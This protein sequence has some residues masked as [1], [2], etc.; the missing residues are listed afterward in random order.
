[1][2]DQVTLPGLPSF[3]KT[4]LGTSRDEGRYGLVLTLCEVWV[5]NGTS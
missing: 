2:A 5:C 1:M 3:G 4:A